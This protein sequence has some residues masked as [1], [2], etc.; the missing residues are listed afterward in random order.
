GK[1]SVGVGSSGNSRVPIVAGQ[2][3]DVRDSTVRVTS[4]D[5]LPAGVELR[6]GNFVFRDMPVATILQTLTRWYGYQFRCADP[7]LARQVVT[8]WLSQRSSATALL[9]L[10]DLLNVNT[11]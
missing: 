5:D 6:R 10:E 7:T 9:T 2:V 1:V 3:G 4:V 8:V 11:T